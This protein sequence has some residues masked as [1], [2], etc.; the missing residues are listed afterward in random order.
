MALGS[1]ATKAVQ[2]GSLTALTHDIFV[3]EWSPDYMDPN[4]NARGFAW[5]PSS[6]AA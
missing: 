4:S 6:G 5:N 1:Q 2:I 3:G